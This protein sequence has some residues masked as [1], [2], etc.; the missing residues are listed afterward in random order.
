MPSISH[1]G[2]N[3]LKDGWVYLHVESASEVMNQV[4]RLEGNR[5]ETHIDGEVKLCQEIF[6]N[7]TQGG[8]FFVSM[9]DGVG[10]RQREDGFDLQ[11]AKCTE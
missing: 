7:Q 8:E 3:S 6:S 4:L 9:F 2:I 11:I 5:C 10:Q 1:S